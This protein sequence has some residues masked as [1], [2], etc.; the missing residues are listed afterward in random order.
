M[1]LL[2]LVFV[3]SFG[4][5]L[6]FRLM[7]RLSASCLQMRHMQRP[8][9]GWS[10]WCSLELEPRGRRRNPTSTSST[11]PIWSWQRCMFCEDNNSRIEVQ[12]IVTSRSTTSMHWPAMMPSCSLD[13]SS[14]F[15]GCHAWGASPAM[16]AQQRPVQRA[17]PAMLAQHRPVQCILT[18]QVLCREASTT[19]EARRSQKPRALPPVRIGPGNQARSER[20]STLG[21]IRAPR[22]CRVCHPLRTVKA[23][24]HH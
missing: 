21:A 13:P 24:W 1:F 3:N 23:V 10:S 17:S 22:Q 5:V 7:L 6:S 15:L 9:A 8:S 19:S 2:I 4:G 18:V 11:L 14:R 20:G 12:G 16:L